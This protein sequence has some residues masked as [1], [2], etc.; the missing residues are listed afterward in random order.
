[1]RSSAESRM[2][3]SSMYT[4]PIDKGIHVSE[5]AA[6]Y[7]LVW[8]GARA[9]KFHLGPSVKDRHLETVTKHLERKG[10]IFFT[11][12]HFSAWSHNKQVLFEI[13]NHVNTRSLEAAVF[14]WQLAGD[15]LV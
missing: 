4:A 14:K 8:P 1:V 7:S 10:Y 5:Y 13:S 9:Q 2:A 6:L 11:S 15:S 12:R 3:P